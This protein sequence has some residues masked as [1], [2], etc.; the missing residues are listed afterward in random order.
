MPWKL[1]LCEIVLCH[2]LAIVMKI[3]C[4][5]DGRKVTKSKAKISVFDN[6]LFYADG[7]FET[8][9]AFGDNIIFLKDHLSRLKKGAELI[10]LKIPVSEK[11]LVTW[12]NR[13]N[14]ANTAS[15]KKIRLTITAGETTF[16]AGKPSRPRVIIIVTDYKMPTSPFRLSVSPY[17]ID[18]ASPFRNVKT[19]SFIIEMT[20]RKHAYSSKYDDAILLSRNGYIAETT[21][22]NIFWVKNGT[23]YT[24]PLEAGCLEGMI[25]KHII[26]IAKSNNI[27]IVEKR[28]R[29][30]TLL[31]ADEIFVS[32]S[33]K[34]IIPVISIT[35]DKTY[36]YKSGRL[37]RK[38]GNLL[39]EYINSGG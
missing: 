19:L 26:A 31:K 12:L 6:S 21:S 8:F 25:R 3:V 4:Y 32:S 7:L 10:D 15:I 17:R 16:W 38:L 11:K 35:T 1:I 14:A 2:I 18:H 29:L 5:I 23:L 39:L 27:P 13:A 9:M 30:R 36:R 20:S 24:P 22:A 34:L 37:T 33:L 28:S